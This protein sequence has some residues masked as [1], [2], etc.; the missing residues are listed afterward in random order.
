MVSII[1]AFIGE[2][3][4]MWIIIIFL[5][6]LSYYPTGNY[7]LKANSVNTWAMCKICSEITMKRLERRQ[8]VS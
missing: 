4:F 6:F 3:I 1:T 7:L 8:V 5:G 2:M